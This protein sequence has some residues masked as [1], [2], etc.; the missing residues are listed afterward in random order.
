M[1]VYKLLQKY[2]T[3]IEKAYEIEKVDESAVHRGEIN[4]IVIIIHNDADSG[5]EEVFSVSVSHLED[6]LTV[7]DYTKAE[8]YKL[9]AENIRSWY[10][11]CNGGGSVFFL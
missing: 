7:V 8:N 9:C 5:K 1:S 10:R 6:C 3:A 2:P 11:L 4:D